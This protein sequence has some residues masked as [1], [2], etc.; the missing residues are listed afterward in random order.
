M[1]LQAISSYPITWC[2]VFDHLAAMLLRLGL[3]WYLKAETDLATLE[4]FKSFALRIICVLVVEWTHFAVSLH[5]TFFFID[6]KFSSQ[7][8]RIELVF[9]IVDRLPAEVSTDL[10]T[11]IYP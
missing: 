6:P 2:V 9:L 5:V 7:I 11:K 4:I 1:P 3:F 8:Q 10:A